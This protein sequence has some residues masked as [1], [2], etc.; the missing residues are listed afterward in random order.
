M[1]ENLYIEHHQRT[2]S[3]Q[4]LNL[5]EPK[6][7]TIFLI[8]IAVGLAR[9]CRWGNQCKNFYSVAEHSVACMLMAEQLYPQNAA[10][11]FACLMHD[12]AEA[13]LG[14][15][16]SELKKLIPQYGEI[17]LRVQKAI[18]V[19][20]GIG[21]PNSPRVKEIDALALEDEW[22]NKMLDWTGLRLDEKSRVDYFIHHVVRLCKHPIPFKP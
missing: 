19:R 13:Y 21:Y 22:E 12:A 15:I 5:L 17:E 20:F 16:P 14:D 6:P 7:T 4:Y 10:L 8:D 3:G 1:S 11:A 9:E 2:Y 18:G